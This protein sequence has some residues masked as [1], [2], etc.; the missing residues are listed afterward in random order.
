MQGL[1]GV[2]LEH[3]FPRLLD[4][5]E[6]RI[7]VGRH[8]Q[9]ERAVRP[10]AAHADDLDREVEQVEAVEQ[11]PD[12][13]GQGLPIAF[14][15]VGV[16]GRGARGLFLGGMEDQRR[17]VLDPRR[18]TQMLDQLREQAVRQALPARLLELFA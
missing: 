13:L 1:A 10:D 4:L 2:R 15:R 6:N 18:R 9:P 3:R 11:R 12:V 8:E 5:Q 14:E 7:V 16:S 17:L